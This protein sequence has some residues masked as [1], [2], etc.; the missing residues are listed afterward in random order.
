M[1]ETQ[2]IGLGMLGVGAVLFL[3]GILFLLD[4]AL[5]TMANLLILAGIGV[6]MTPIGFYKFIAQRGK[7]QGTI[8]F[9]LGIALVLCKLPLPGIIC[10]LTGAY[11]LFGGF[12]PMLLSL[13]TKLPKIGKILPFISKLKGEDLPL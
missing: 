10:E 8:A 5:L 13:I 4:R 12:W 3:L 11:W 1:N 7:G 2:T 6:L 9:F